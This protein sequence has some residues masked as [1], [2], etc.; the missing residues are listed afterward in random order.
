MDAAQIIVTIVGAGLIGFI[1]W[2]FFGQ[3]LANR[4]TAT[5]RVLEKD[6]RRSDKPGAVLPSNSD[7]VLD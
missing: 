1:L 4:P 5:G 6:E 7:P 2:F 3:R